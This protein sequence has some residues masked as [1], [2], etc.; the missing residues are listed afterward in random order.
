LNARLILR[1]FPFWF[2]LICLN[3][4]AARAQMNLPDSLAIINLYDR[5]LDFPASKADSMQLYANRILAASAAIQYPMGELYG[6]RLIGISHELKGHYDKALQQY[7]KLL[8]LANQRNDASYKVTALSDMAILYTEGLN[9]PEKSKEVYKEILRV[10]RTNNIPASVSL[11]TY[12]NLGAIYTRLKKYD[13]SLIILNLGLR[14]A[15]LIDDVSS[16]SSIYN[17]IGNVYYQKGDY[18]RALEYFQR[19]YQQH[20]RNATEEE[21]WLDYLNMG[22]SWLALREL[23]SAKKYLSLALQQAQ[24]NDDALQLKE[25]YSLLAKLHYNTK[26]YAKAYDWLQKTYDTDTSLLNI[27]TRNTIATLQEQFN[28]AEREK[29]NQLLL[30]NIEKAKFQNR[31]SLAIAL[32]ALLIG[33]AIAYA[34]FMKRKANQTLT[35][36][37]E[38]ITQQNQRLTTLNFEKNKL[39]SMVSHDLSTPFASVRMW[40]EVLR[41]QYQPP[42]QSEADPASNQPPSAPTV[43]P[44]LALNKILDSAQRGESLIQQML[45]VEKMETGRQ[46]L[47]LEE[48]QFSRLIAHLLEDFETKAA[49]KQITL[50]LETPEAPVLLLTDRKLIER[51]FQNLLSNALKFTPSGKRVWVRIQETPEQVV[52]QVADEGPGIEGEDIRKLFTPYGQLSARPTAGES[53][54]GLGLSIVKRL[55]EELQGK[56][57]CQ[58]TLGVGCTFTVELPR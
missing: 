41:R 19:N 16:L 37:N 58:S 23:D 1:F 14:E 54:T 36:L 30:I 27:D 32:S 35:E 15:L 47:D 8:E 11:S 52:L 31:I 49:S 55:V 10:Q 3:G 42:N 29:A 5:C 43:S 21:I 28:A 12:V 33:V 48:I 25:S 44:E 45:Q 9:L 39:M 26:E 2:T 20:V 13:S 18:R 51:I 57:S 46:A 53:S 34:W 7:L 24:T 50:T 4:P 40:A 38:T 17:N 22:D 6:T 56:V